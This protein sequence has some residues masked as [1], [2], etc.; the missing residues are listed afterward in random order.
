M[1]LCINVAKYSLY[2]SIVAAC[3]AFHDKMWLN[4]QSNYIMIIY[5]HGE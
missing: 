3:N 4:D 5:L 1:L 2:V